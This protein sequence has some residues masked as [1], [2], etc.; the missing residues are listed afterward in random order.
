MAKYL[1]QGAGAVV[2][3]RPA[4]AYRRMSKAC[5]GPYRIDAKG[6]RAEGGVVQPIVAGE[7]TASLD[8]QYWDIQLRCGR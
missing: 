6:P 2:K 7:S 3:R 4:D 1:N 5:G 8:V